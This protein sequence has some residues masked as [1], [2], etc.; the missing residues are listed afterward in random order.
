MSEIIELTEDQA[1]DFKN[2]WR[3]RNS[4]NWGC[5]PPSSEW[6]DVG[7]GYTATQIQSGKR[8]YVHIKFDCEVHMGPIIDRC[9]DIR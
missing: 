7:V 2:Y 3:E 5:W 8:V 9:H 6:P 4:E 1:K